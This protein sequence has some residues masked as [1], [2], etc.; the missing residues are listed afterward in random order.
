M[1]ICRHAFRPRG[2]MRA[3]A[4]ITNS[5]KTIILQKYIQKN[6]YLYIYISLLNTFN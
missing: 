3:T 2:C 5:F 1:P 6:I 4:K